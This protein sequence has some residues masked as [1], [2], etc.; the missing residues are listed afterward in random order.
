MKPT[1]RPHAVETL[2]KVP[3]T[4]PEGLTIQGATAKVTY[5]KSVA[6]DV[7][8]LH[9]VY[10]NKEQ[11]DNTTG[12]AN[13]DLASN[14]PYLKAQGFKADAKTNAVIVN[15]KQQPVLAIGLGDL[16]K[17]KFTANQFRDTVHAATKKAKALNKNHLVIN[18]PTNEIADLDK[19]M[20]GYGFGV[21]GTEFGFN[22]QNAVKAEELVHHTIRSAITANYM[23]DRYLKED[24]IKAKNFLVNEVTLVGDADVDANVIHTAVHAAESE[25]FTRAVGNLRVNVANNTYMKDLCEELVK[26][27]SDA[28]T[29]RVLDREALKEQGYTLISAVGQG[30]VESPYIVTMEYTPPNYTETEDAKAIAV[31][32]KTLTF[33]TGGLDLKPPAAMLEMHMDKLGGCT[34]LGL[35]RA[36]AL[37]R[38]QTKNKVVFTLGICENA[39]GPASYYPKVIIDTVKGSVSVDN[40]D[41]EG[42]LVLADAFQ[43][44]Q[45]H[46]KIGKIIDM[47]TLTGAILITLGHFA[48]GLFTNNKQIAE[49]ITATGERYGELFWN[50]PIL[51]QNHEQLNGTDCDITNISK[52]RWC[53][54][55][56]AAAFLEKYVEDGVEFCHLDI[57]GSAYTTETTGACLATLYDYV[58]KKH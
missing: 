15:D 43:F 57:A 56:T 4:K 22:K 50:L 16:S 55:S 14:L 58:S 42:R 17:N 24:T 38:P 33:D 2:I 28:F 31:I 53:G 30:S 21:K 48:T 3:F 23:F 36:F 29:I 51:S 11:F 19:T 39:I 47:A 25:V 52:E 8:A 54:S 34:T 41:A 1:E 10:I 40:T 13:V 5:A 9:V 45:K 7:D 44:T 20:M 6:S 37:T 12:S 26:T 49:D 46:Y 27:H 18:L 35:A 32:G